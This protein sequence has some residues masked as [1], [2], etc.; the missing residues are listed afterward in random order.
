MCGI[1][2]YIDFSGHREQQQAIVE[3]MGAT[4]VCRGPDASGIYLSEHA[5]FAHRRLIVIDPEGG[6]QPMVRSLFHSDYCITYNGE[7]YNMDE[8]RSELLLRGHTLQTRS[9]TELVLLAYM[10]WGPACVEKLNGI[11]AIGIWNEAEQ[12]LFLARDRLGVKPLYFAKRDGIFAFGSEIKAILAHPAIPPEVDAT[13]LAELCFIGP[14]RTPGLAVFKHINEVRPG[15]FVLH[16]RE[17]TSE[18]TYWRL[19]SKPHEHD[20]KTTAQ[21][22]RDLLED[23]VS[24]QLVSDVPLATLLSGGLDSSIV[25]AFAA[26]A[27]KQNGK[28]TL[29]TYSVDFIGM[30]EHFEANAF[31]TGRDAPWVA[32]VAEFLQTVHHDIVLDTDDLLK[33]LLQPLAARDLPGMADIDISLL[34]FCQEIKKNATVALSGEAADEV[35][36]GYPWFHRPEVLSD[37]TFPWSRRLADRIRY[38]HPALAGK[39]D[40]TAYVAER[41]SDAIKEV[42][43]LYGEDKQEARIR[44]ISYLNLTRFLP[45]LLERK[46]R[47]S[48]AAGLE[49]RV[50]FCD[51]RLIEYVWNIPWFLKSLNG[52]PKAILR[53]AAEDILPYDVV[54][55]KKSPYPSTAHPAYLEGTRA[56]VEAILADAS[57]P[58]LD[59]IDVS[60]LRQTLEKSR[61]RLE[62]EPWFGQIM[63]TPQLFDYIIQINAWMKTHRVTLV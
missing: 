42:P 27:L 21:H 56:R 35:F 22:V 16:T 43:R 17:H 24:R 48:M 44:E 40:P 46:D 31:Q 5:A 53:K 4:L 49:V 28:E 1:A 61:G 30:D 26:R 6:I 37:N 3:A 60:A 19:E 50:P 29:H 45:T 14:A 15:T 10:E 34:L 51:H 63:A 55:R 2:G 32:R 62:H 25:S 18:H 36:G 11:F 38:F 41:Y 54:Y 58:V 52:T 33:H 59:L 20:F 39:L 13:G 23:A 47:M 8:L 9:D 57:S 12:T 7:L